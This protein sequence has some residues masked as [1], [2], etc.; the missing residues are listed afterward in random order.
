MALVDEPDGRLGRCQV[1]QAQKVHLQEPGFLDVPHF[2]LGGDDLLGLV[3]V[4]KLLERD[5]LFQ[6]PVGDHHAG[7]VSADAPV[8]SF[9]AT[10]EIQK[11]GNFRV[12]VGHPPQGRFF[13]DGLV[14]RD[15]ETGGDQLVDLLDAR[16]RNVQGPSHVLEGG[17]GFQ[18]AEG[19]DLGH[20]GVAV[21]LAD[22][23]D[24]LVP[25]RLAEVDVDVGR[26]GATGVEKSLE[27]AGRI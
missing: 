2:P 1:A 20:I 9:Q 3:F 27:Q 4:G 23:L 5:E 25:P 18:G 12:F 6:R 16:Q 21:L 19:A 15:V 8:H 14:E 10:G 7:G 17:L 13:L 26:L 11:L 24:D 22:V